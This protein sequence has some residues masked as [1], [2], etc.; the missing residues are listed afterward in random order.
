[1]IALS[2]KSDGQRTETKTKLSAVAV[3]VC[4][5]C[6]PDTGGDQSLAWC[7]VIGRPSSSGTVGI[8]SSGSASF[9]ESVEGGKVFNG[10][11]D[12]FQTVCAYTDVSRSGNIMTYSLLQYGSYIRNFP[13]L[14]QN[15]FSSALRPGCRGK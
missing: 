3:M 1:M 6:L 4:S 13:D 2:R 8:C 12:V 10:N 15:E 11:G 5:S 9:D 7:V 14:P